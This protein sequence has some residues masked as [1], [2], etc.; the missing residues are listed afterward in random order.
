MI[1]EDLYQKA[2]VAIEKVHSTDLIRESYNGIDYPSEVLYSNRMLAMLDTIYP[3]STL[4]LK[5]AIQCQHL[6][7]WGIPR[8]DYPFDKRGY[9]QWRRM[10]MEYQIQQTMEILTEINMESSDIHLIVDALKNQG[11]KTNENAQII[12]D[13][14]CLVFLKWYLQPF[15]AKH[16]Q[17]KVSDILKKTMRKM[18]EQGISHTKTIDLSPSVLR[19]L[20]SVN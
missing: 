20:T 8:A 11:D 16:E 4:I 2:I 12:L 17:S 19:I 5:I 6:K 14:A 3:N 10:V 13:T 15:A 7:R 18:S 1:T 9:H